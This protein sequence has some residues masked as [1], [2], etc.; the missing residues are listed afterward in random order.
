M[1]R[2]KKII[3]QLAIA[4]LALTGCGDGDTDTG[5]AG[6]DAGNGDAGTGGTGGTAGTGG[7][8]GNGTPGTDLNGALGAWCMTLA[9]CFPESP[10]YQ[11]TNYCVDYHLN[12][13]GLNGDISAACQTAAIS[14]FECGTGLSCEQLGMYN[15]DCNPQ[16]YAADD[17]C[18]AW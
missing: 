15:N 5:D 4:M 10:Y 7:T 3:P 6:T 1:F 2:P 11:P 16:W 12:W 8:G 18:P 9:G 17:T 14:Y 13:Y